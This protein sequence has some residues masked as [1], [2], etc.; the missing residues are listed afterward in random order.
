MEMMDSEMIISSTSSVVENI[1]IVGTY[2]LTFNFEDIANNN[3]NN[4]NIN[5]IVN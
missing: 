4:I 5:L 1:N 2:S 3:L